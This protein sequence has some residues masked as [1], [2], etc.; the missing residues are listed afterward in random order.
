MFT[1]GKSELDFAMYAGMD[2]SSST[3]MIPIVFKVREDGVQTAALSH[4]DDGG[5]GHACDSPHG[6]MRRSPSR[7]RWRW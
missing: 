5:S 7:M 6:P 1:V 2:K 4:A 3:K